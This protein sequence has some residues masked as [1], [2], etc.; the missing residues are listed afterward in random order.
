MVTILETLDQVG[1]VF[2]NPTEHIFHVS[3]E[4]EVHLYPSGLSSI[5]EVGKES[6][7]PASPLYLLQ[8]PMNKY[9]VGVDDKN[10]NC[11]HEKS[12]LGWNKLAFVQSAILHHLP[13]EKGYIAHCLKKS[14]LSSMTD[15]ALIEQNKLDWTEVIQIVDNCTNLSKKMQE[16][17]Q[18]EINALL[19]TEKFVQERGRRKRSQSVEKNTTLLTDTSASR[20]RRSGSGEK[21]PALLTKKSASGLRNSRSPSP[22]ETQTSRFEMPKI[23]RSQ[24]NK[25]SYT[26]DGSYERRASPGDSLA[27][28]VSA[29]ALS[30]RKK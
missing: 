9:R 7:L 30:M 11:L 2:T 26:R 28:A 25:T 29:L 15:E 10:P 5:Y 8:Q 6:Y 14:L 17:L 21:N 3:Q 20:R 19:I 16:T 27:A 4:G 18:A 24:E 12:Q 22:R 13:A 1:A 23:K